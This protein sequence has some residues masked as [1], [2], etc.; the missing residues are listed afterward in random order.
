MDFDTPK[1]CCLKQIQQNSAVL[2]RG[3]FGI[4][5]KA[6]Y[7]EKIV[8]VKIISKRDGYKYSSIKRERNI[9][10]LSNP[11]IIKILKIVDSKEYGAI[12]MER[13]ENSRNLQYIL[14][15]S[16][17]IALIHRLKILKDVAHALKFCKMNYIIHRDLKPDNLMIVFDH[18]DYICKLFDFGCSYKINSIAD[19]AY[20]L[21]NGQNEGDFNDSVVG[22]VRYSAP[23]LL[24]GSVPTYSIDVYSFGIL[25]WQLKQNEIPYQTIKSN[26]IIIWQVVKNN[27]R[28]DSTLLLLNDLNEKPME[29]RRDDS[30]KMLRMSLE[31]KSL[32]PKKLLIKSSEKS[33]RSDFKLTRSR[34]AVNGSKNIIRKSLFKSTLLD[35]LNNENEVDDGSTKM[36]INYL[37]DQQ[38]Y[39]RQ[40]ESLF[41]IENEYVRLYKACWDEKH[42]FRP[43][44]EKICNLIE[45]FINYL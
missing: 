10:N 36:F 21:K 2:G 38:F 42:L 20:V 25:M 24:Q 19:Q 45:K 5:F 34:C 31:V 6:L 37:T 8:A 9:L 17:K 39:L 7:R 23:E 32:T 11:N 18:N 44:V 30:N 13:F 3:S 35:S 27:L 16:D 12:I 29:I 15:H 40:P 33:S 28:P 22:T 26:E 14:D 43:D 4:V 41:K 1:R